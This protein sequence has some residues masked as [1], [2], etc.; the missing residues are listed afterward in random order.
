MI[1]SKR[2]FPA[3]R[4]AR[5]AEDVDSDG[6]SAM[7]QVMLAPETARRP[8]GLRPGF[9][10]MVRRWSLVV[11]LASAAVLA[12]CS[13][14]PELLE[15][16]PE[17]TALLVQMPRPIQHRSREVAV[18]DQTLTA[19]AYSASFDGVVY[20]VNHQPIP[21]A[22]QQEMRRRPIAG[23][24]DAMQAQLVQSTGGTV[25]K[26]MGAA[27]PTPGASFQG[28]EVA[29]RLPDGRHNTIVRVFPADG[30]H[31]QVAVTLPLAP[32]YN[33]ELYAMRFLDSVR[34]R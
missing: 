24:L 10:V 14:K 7:P 9:E 29:L 17:G 2:A 21:P 27:L 13:K 16:S 26:Q 19:H 1:D 34:L 12:G 22:V 15:F 25:V 5:R 3:Q 4:T 28:R 11:L 23:V 30:I 31:V 18:A 8:F 33:Q 6:S 32:S 20:V